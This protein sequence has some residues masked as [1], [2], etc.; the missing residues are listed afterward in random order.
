MDK[1]IARWEFCR[2]D[3]ECIATWAEI[4]RLRRSAAFPHGSWGE[5]EDGVHL[6]RYMA[7]PEFDQEDRLLGEGGFPEIDP[8]LSYG[9]LTAIQRFML[10]AG[11]K[12]A[13]TIFRRTGEF[14]AKD[15]PLALLMKVD[16]SVAKS[17]KAIFDQLG[18]VFDNYFLA[19]E[20]MQSC[21]DRNSC[22]V[23]L[24]KRKKELFETAGGGTRLKDVSPF[25]TAIRNINRVNLPGNEEETEGG[26]TEDY[27][28]ILRAGDMYYRLNGMEYEKR[29]GVTQAKIAQ[30]IFPDDFVN[31]YDGNPAAKTTRT[32]KL[33]RLYISLVYGGW[34]AIRP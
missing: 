24:K 23:F 14:R 11:V 19:K 34:R 31:S 8:A 17:K 13:I 15:D 21:N 4:Q 7:T 29:D 20:M 2:R 27:E 1:I 22:Y 6:D 25:L 18:T 16:F 5:N 12:K 32:G 9:E 10:H 28:K 26:G 30:A 3:P 33:C